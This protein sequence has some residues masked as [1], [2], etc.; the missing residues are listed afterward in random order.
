MELRKRIKTAYRYTTEADAMY[1][2]SNAITRSITEMLAR[3]DDYEAYTVA[4]LIKANELL[5]EKSQ[6][7][8]DFIN[9]AIT[10][11]EKAIDEVERLEEC[12]SE[13]A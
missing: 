7:E 2:I 4:A 1:Y 12:R 3:G 8:G 11:L 5:L 6:E 13:S 10:D 9:S